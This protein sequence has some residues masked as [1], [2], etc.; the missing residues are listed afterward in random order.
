MLYGLILECVR[1]GIILTYGS[2]IWKRIVH[3]VDLPTETFDLFTHYPD[4]LML[5][6]CDCM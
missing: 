2:N 4:D 3:E 1:N 5:S 6:I